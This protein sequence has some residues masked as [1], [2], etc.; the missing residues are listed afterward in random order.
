MGLAIVEDAAGI[1]RTIAGDRGIDNIGQG[2]LSQI[3]RTA[4][5]IDFIFIKRTALNR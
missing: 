4:D 2:I 1:F 5:L 3:Y